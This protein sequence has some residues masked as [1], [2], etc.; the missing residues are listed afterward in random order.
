MPDDD[1][2]RLQDFL[3]YLLNHTA[4]DVGQGFARIYKDRY[5]MLRT[6]WRVL[7]HLGQFGPMDATRIGSMARV[8]KTKISRA[9]AAL[10]DKRFVTRDTDQGDRRR[11][12]LCLT[13]AG[14]AA[15]AD[16]A[17]IARDHD[18]ALAARL[19]PQEHATLLRCLKKLGQ[20]LP[21]G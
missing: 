18:R 10:T 19:T 8:H 17:A 9:V 1:P 21:Q 20:D 11:A 7:A 4:E 15:Y 2:F 14:Q 5:G 12:V 13:R 16:L 3:P 6:E